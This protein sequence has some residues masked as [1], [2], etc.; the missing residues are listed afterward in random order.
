VAVF[1][2]IIVGRDYL[3]NIGTAPFDF[4]LTY[5]CTLTTFQAGCLWDTYFRIT[6]DITNETSQKKSWV[7]EENLCLTL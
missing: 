4:I 3:L 7:L 5:S 1:R 6:S 2:P